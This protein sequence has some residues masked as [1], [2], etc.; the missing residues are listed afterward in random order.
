MR[1]TVTADITRLTAAGRNERFD[2]AETL[3]GRWTR[4]RDSVLATLDLWSDW[5]RDA[6]LVAAAVEER[7]HVAGA[8]AT[9]FTPVEALS[10]LQAVQR[11]REHL[12]QNTNAQLAIEVMMLDLPVRTGKEAREP[13]TAAR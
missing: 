12:L 2:Y 4:E 10:A 7:P 6:L 11:A 13:A 9:E 1:E 5:W 3:A 8:V